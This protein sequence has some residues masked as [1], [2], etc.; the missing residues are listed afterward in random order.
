M[1]LTDKLLA[2]LQ[3]AMRSGDTERRDTLRMLRAAVQNEEIARRSPLDDESV[4]EVLRREAKKRQ[5]P[6]ELFR[7]AG[8]E[9]LVQ[10]TEAELALIAEYLPQ[11]MSTDELE[12]VVRQAIAEA[13]V[14]DIR[15]LGAV[16][17][18]VMPRV[19]GKADGRQVNEAVRRLL[20]EPQQ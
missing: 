11:A 10:E 20:S 2:D 1:G 18:L 6:L 3:A 15:G 13:G 19:K 5:E 7:T 16:M 4:V 8:R 17:K 14:R 9:D 12:A